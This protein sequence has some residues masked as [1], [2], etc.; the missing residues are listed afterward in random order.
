MFNREIEKVKQ[1]QTKS[2]G[3]QTRFCHLQIRASGKEEN[4]DDPNTPHTSLL[5][6]HN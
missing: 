6:C 1:T 2:K 5:S 4:A 3:R